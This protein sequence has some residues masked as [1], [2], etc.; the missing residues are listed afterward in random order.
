[1]KRYT[2]CVKRVD[3]LAEGKYQITFKESFSEYPVCTFYAYPE[4]TDPNNL[5]YELRRIDY[6]VSAPNPP[7]GQII[8]KTGPPSEEGDVIT[9]K[10]T[11]FNFICTELQL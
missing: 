6:Y 3:P 9:R 7:Y 4:F 10:D 2:S 11:T 5:F 8:V 1:M